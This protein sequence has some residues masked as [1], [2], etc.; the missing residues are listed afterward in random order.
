[1]AFEDQLDVADFERVVAAQFR[2]LASRRDDV[3]DELVGERENRLSRNVSMRP[4]LRDTLW[5]R[6][7]LFD[8]RLKTFSAAACHLPD[9][10]VQLLLVQDVVAGTLQ[11]V[12]RSLLD[13]RL[14]HHANLAVG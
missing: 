8:I 13:R 2:E 14:A 4:V 5:V 9:E 1:V 6:S 3:V 11:H 12:G 7:H 10:L